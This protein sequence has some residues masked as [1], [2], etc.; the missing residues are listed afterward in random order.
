MNTN[1]VNAIIAKAEFEAFMEKYG[2]DPRSDPIAK[3]DDL[4]LLEDGEEALENMKPHL[5]EI[6]RVLGMQYIEP[7]LTAEGAKMLIEHPT[8]FYKEY[9][10][11]LR[12]IIKHCQGDL[13]MI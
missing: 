9:V 8:K 11:Q 2:F 5:V 1:I 4:L 13:I 10:S 7:M 3:Y 6:S 12:H